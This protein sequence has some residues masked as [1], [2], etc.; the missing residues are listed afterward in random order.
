MGQ[1]W[2]LVQLT[3]LESHQRF[4]LW[5]SYLEHV[6]TVI[7]FEGKY[8]PNTSANSLL[9]PYMNNQTVCKQVPRWSTNPTEWCLSRFQNQIKVHEN[10]EHLNLS[11]NYEFQVHRN[12]RADHREQTGKWW[13]ITMYF[14]WRS[15]QSNSTML[16]AMKTAVQE[17][18]TTLWHIGTCPPSEELTRRNQLWQE[19][20]HVQVNHICLPI[21]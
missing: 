4:S 20:W 8:A 12:T 21:N 16:H 5:F 6:P 7:L 1:L 15:L 3:T 10:K 17:A 9:R 2:L 18:K 19:E 11:G 14:N 13:K